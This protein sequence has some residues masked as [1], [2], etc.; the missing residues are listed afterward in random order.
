MIKY[1]DLQKPTKLTIMK[2]DKK[3][4]EVFVPQVTGYIDID[5]F[6]HVETTYDQ[7]DNQFTMRIEV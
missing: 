5:E 4:S 6:K 3:I 1:V 2:D 7:I